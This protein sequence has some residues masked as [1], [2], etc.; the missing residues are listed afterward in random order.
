MGELNLEVKSCTSL[1]YFVALVAHV[2]E[3]IT[4]H[5]QLSSRLPSLLHCLDDRGRFDV[6]K[7]IA[8]QRQKRQRQSLY[9]STEG[10]PLEDPLPKP[11]KRRGTKGDWKNETQQYELVD[12]T[13][14]YW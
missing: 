6:A 12:P 2:A 10:F 14:S 9:L 5:S 1:H 4:V 3:K 8:L 7:C 13:K 11:K